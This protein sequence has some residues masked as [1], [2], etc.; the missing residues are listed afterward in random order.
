MEFIG[1]ILIILFLVLVIGSILGFVAISR[2]STLERD[3]I[4]LKKSINDLQPGSAP[5]KQSD[6]TIPLPERIR[7]E[8][9][10]ETKIKLPE[11]SFAKPTPPAPT[12]VAKTQHTPPSRKAPPSKEPRKW[13]EEFG[14]R[15]TVWVGGI[16]LAFG[17]VFLLR[18][19][20]E[21]GIF[22]PEMRLGLAGIMGLV[23]LGFGE[24]LRRVDP[25]D[26]KLPDL[27]RSTVDNAYIPGVLTAV[28]I[29]TLLGTVY[30][31]Y[32]IYDLFGPTLTFAL[33]G[34]FSLAGLTLGLIHGPRM[35]ALGLLAALITPLLVHTGTP[36]YLILFTYLLIVG[37]AAITLAVKREWQWLILA[38]FG[39]LLA[40]AAFT[41]GAASRTDFIIW[42]I[43]MAIIYLT[44][45]ALY[46]KSSTAEEE[47]HTHF[48]LL[49]FLIGSTV[50]AVI[51]WLSVFINNFETPQLA[52]AMGFA[53]VA[54]ILGWRNKS[55]SLKIIL[56]GALAGFLLCGLASNKADVV[57]LL[58][59]AVPPMVL[60]IDFGTL[61]LR[62]ETDPKT[63][64]IWA[65]AVPAIPLATFASWPYVNIW[66]S[67][68]ATGSIM[69]VL[70]IVFVA[71]AFLHD[72][73]KKEL[74]VHTHLVAAAL[75]YFLAAVI[76][77]TG[78]PVSL[79][80]MV[81]IVLTV[82]LSLR[83]KSDVLAYI[84][85]G[86]GGCDAAHVFFLE[87]PTE[88]RESSQI[89]LNQLWVYHALPA[90]L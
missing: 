76:Y 57:T 64:T 24:L 74:A 86:F 58:A 20:A 51:I 40:W 56:G 11:K 43:Y 12:S 69:A 89:I 44:A 37:G 2:V 66:L 80:L 90:V 65:F 3:V 52:F 28:G 61:A 73:A 48:E 39:G 16:A 85:L 47:E 54:M 29:F 14:A 78:L 22:T 1:V 17:A 13:E 46:W 81:G 82:V 41:V 23:A 15:W 42:A 33:L 67:D 26:A 87:L 19:A 71:L 68:T 49:S 35:S 27:A 31:A 53:V 8:P 32:G 9:K 77:F 45:L 72:H 25:T 60:F 75:A 21:A 84:A 4:K 70:A 30:A 5:I 63:H 50:I 7:P 34:L 18:Y 36:Q 62:R 38:A 79:A 10:P 6:P 88:R 55:L 59:W 83:L